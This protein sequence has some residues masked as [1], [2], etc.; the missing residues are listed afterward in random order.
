MVLPTSN[1]LF[2]KKFLTGIIFWLDFSWFQMWSNWQPRTAITSLNSYWANLEWNE[3]ILASQVI[4][5]SISV[6][7]VAIFSKKLGCSQPEHARFPFLPSWPLENLYPSSFSLFLPTPILYTQIRT[8][9][10]YG[11]LFYSNCHVSMSSE[12]RSG[13]SPLMYKNKHFASPWIK[14]HVLEQLLGSCPKPYLASCL[15]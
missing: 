14:M 2:K 8:S 11:K 12:V 3:E 6:K 10:L 4:I 5:L 13:Q 7:I 1:H 9:F 15:L